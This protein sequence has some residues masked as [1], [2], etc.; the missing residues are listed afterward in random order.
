LETTEGTMGNEQ[1]RDTGNIS[2]KTK[3]EEQKHKTKDEEKN[4]KTKKYQ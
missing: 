4:H 3:D 2:H 1:S